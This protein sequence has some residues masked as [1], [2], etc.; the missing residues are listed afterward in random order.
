AL[1]PADDIG[2]ADAAY[3]LE[4]FK[5]HLV[6]DG[7]Q[8]AQVAQV[9]ADRDRG[10]RLAFRAEAA[11]L[12]VF[13]LVAEARGDQSHFLAHILH[14]FHGVDGQLECDDYRRA[15]F[16]RARGKRPY[17]ADRVDRLLDRACDLALDALRRGAGIIRA[18][19][20]DRE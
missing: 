4:S 15:A 18:D 17:A 5:D 12:R 14:G 9:A 8:L 13:D 19:H 20:D 1:D 10:D 16:Q 6:G 3:G 7:G 11:D 2:A